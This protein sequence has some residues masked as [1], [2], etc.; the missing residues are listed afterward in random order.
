MPGDALSLSNLINSSYRGD[1]A[2]IGWTHEAELVDGLRITP[3]EIEA[4]INTTGDFFLISES[5]GELMGTVHVK[6]EGLGMY[7]GMLAVR[8][9]RQ[10]KK[11]GSGLIEEV[12]RL[13]REQ[14][15]QFIRI[16]VIHLRKELVSYYERKGFVVTGNSEP[17][18]EKYPAKIPGLRLIEMKKTL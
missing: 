11:T 12:T 3:E 17:F 2:R 15:K 14:S 10:N 16:S 8:P 7:F 9:D 6:N 4:I 1:S 13:A 5:E 18:P